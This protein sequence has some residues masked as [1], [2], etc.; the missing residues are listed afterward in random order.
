MVG[1]EFESALEMMVAY[2]PGAALWEGTVNPNPT[3]VHCEPQPHY[4]ALLA[5]T[6]LQCTVNPNRTVT[7]CGKLNPSTI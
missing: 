2:E 1:Q 4:S 6:P 7:R 3:T 5:P